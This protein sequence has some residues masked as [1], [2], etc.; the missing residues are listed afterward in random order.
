MQN[1]SLDGEGFK[2]LGENTVLELL[3]FIVVDILVWENGIKKNAKTGLWG[4]TS[5]MVKN[6]GFF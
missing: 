2:R 5:T 3:I 1:L 6:G 4:W